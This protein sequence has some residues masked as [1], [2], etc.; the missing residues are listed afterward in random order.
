MEF[1]PE[2]KGAGMSDDQNINDETGAEDEYEEITSDEVDRVVGMLEE[3]MGFIQSENIKDYLEEASTNIYHL[4][5]DEEE[6]D[7]SEAA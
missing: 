5:Y 4:V 1:S 3:L 2:S 7:V 6:G